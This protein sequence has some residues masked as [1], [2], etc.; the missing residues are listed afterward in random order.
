M[1]IIHVL[2]GKANPNTMNGVNKV[3][4]NLATE[5]MKLGYDVE[6]W[7]LTGTPSK[8]SHA[9][10]YNLRLFTV[11]KIR[12]L[13]SASLSDAIKE[14]KNTDVIVHLHSVFLPE[15]YAVS[16]KLKANNITWVLSPHSGYNFNSLKKNKYMKAIYIALF[17]K[18]LVSQSKRIHAIGQSEIQDIKA[19]SPS[20]E[21]VLI[22]NGQSLLDVEFTPQPVIKEVEKPVF[23]FCGRLAKD[24]KG[25]DLLISAFSQYKNNSGKGV[26]WLIGH[27]P[28]A[29]ALKAQVQFLGISQYVHFF[30]TKFT[31]EKLSIMSNM[32]VF[33]HTSRWDVYPTATLEAA[34]LKTPLLLS[35]ETNMGAHVKQ[36]GCGLILEDNSVECIENALHVFSSLEIEKR[37]QMG[38][39]AKRLIKDELN[40]PNL[41]LAVTENLYGLSK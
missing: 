5:Q 30:G 34:A 18:K 2:L 25:L 1:K 24:H 4:H 8:V 6:V 9:H 39:S 28:D 13:L 20:S 12:F 7:G 3:V 32:D 31:D 23:G 38:I 21:I 19:I 29:D 36:F 27:G 10:D 14:L 26:L 16:R 37:I 11:Q 22:P 35:E 17:E 41:S 33:I 15:L 40:W